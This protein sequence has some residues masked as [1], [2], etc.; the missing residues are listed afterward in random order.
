VTGFRHLRSIFGINLKPAR[1]VVCSIVAQ[2][3]EPLAYNAAVMG[4]TK[5]SA[6]SLSVRPAVFSTFIV[7][8]AFM[9]AS[10][11]AQPSLT[12]RGAC[13]A[14]LALEQSGHPPEVSSRASCHSAFIVDGSPE[15]MRNEVAS[16]LA[17]GARPSLDDLAVA[18][19]IAEAAVRKA[20]NQ[21]WGYLARCDIARRLGNADVL[22]TCLADLRR[23]APD[24]PATARARAFASEPASFGIHLVRVLLLLAL[25]GTLAD[26]L[27][28]RER[29]SRR[30]RPPVPAKPVVLLLA[31]C[32]LLSTAGAGVA[33]A[34]PTA[35]RDQ[36]SDFKIDDADPEAGIPTVE[37]QNSKPLEFGYYLQDLAAKAEKAGK[38]GDHAKEA[39]YYRA[40]TAA[41]PLASFGPRKLCDALEAAG[42]L[43][44][45]IVACRTAITR[46]GSTAGDYLHFV[47]L[48]L[49]T[50]GPLEP[51]EREELNVVIAHLDGEAQLGALPTMFRCEVALRFQDTPGLAACTGTL[52]RIAPD[53]PKTVSFQWALALQEHDRSKALQLLDRAR[54]MGMAKDGVAKMER[55]TRQMTQR[56]VGRF[57]LLALGAGLAAALLALGFRHLAQRRRVAA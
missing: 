50:K 9:A 13:E 26:A 52:S 27:L 42:D 56:L 23:V 31:V 53:D 32:S 15:D 36:L 19:L 44:N 43:P 17:P 41:A 33:R 48:V 40:L 3:I 16:L 49:A 4:F 38:A 35:G 5:R 2:P 20:S 51:A 18:T 30:P 54:S 39:R 25:L 1:T 37:A 14:A 22:E 11:A 8:T 10:A 47:R 57:T 24:H 29:L 34:E 21:P 45:A 46:Q 12:S 55:A 7:A 28:R 6:S